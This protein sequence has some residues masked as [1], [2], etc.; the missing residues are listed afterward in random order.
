MSTWRKLALQFRK[1]M[2]ATEDVEKQNFFHYRL[3]TYCIAT[4]KTLSGC[5]N[6]N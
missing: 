2:K 1:K 6:H 4:K 3:Q 5:G